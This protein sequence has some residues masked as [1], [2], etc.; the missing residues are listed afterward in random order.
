MQNIY[1]RENTTAE[2]DAVGGEPLIGSGFETEQ[3]E[4][5]FEVDSTA[6]EEDEAR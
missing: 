5:D 2:I 4:F 1:T 6:D 3:S